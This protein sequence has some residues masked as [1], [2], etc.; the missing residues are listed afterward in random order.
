MDIIQHTKEKMAA[1]LEHLRSELKSIRTGRANPG[2]LDN[3]QVE[4]YGS[5]MRIKECASITTP[6]PRM[7]LVTPFEPKNSSVIGKAIEKANLGVTPIVD[8]NVVRI[9]ISQMDDSVRKEMVKLCH[10][11]LEEAKI[12]IRNIRRDANEAVRKQKAAGDIAEDIMKKN[13]KTIQ[14]LTDK[15]CKEA[16]EITEKKEKEVSTI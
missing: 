7:L 3:V 12:S 13:E 10:K 6:E 14:D 8:G 16:D 5:M 9:K 2:M 4:I 1:A 15:S 11:R